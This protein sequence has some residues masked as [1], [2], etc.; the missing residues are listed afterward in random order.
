MATMPVSSIRT[1]EEYAAGQLQDVQQ[2]ATLLSLFGGMSVVL[3]LTGSL[4]GTVRRWS[5]K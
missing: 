5:P 1:V 3:A 2:Y 4:P